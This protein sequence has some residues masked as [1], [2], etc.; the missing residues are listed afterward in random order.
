MRNLTDRL[1]TLG[2]T[3]VRGYRR[4]SYQNQCSTVLPKDLSGQ[5]LPHHELDR[6]GSLH[7]VDCNLLLRELL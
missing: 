3:M 4:G 1:D 5:S 7:H 2:D 6:D